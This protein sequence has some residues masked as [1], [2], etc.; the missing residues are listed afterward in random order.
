MDEDRPLGRGRVQRV[1]WG[2]FVVLF[3][4]TL[5]RVLGM[6]PSNYRRSGSA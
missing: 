6:E 2:G 4:L 5:F 3:P 1:L